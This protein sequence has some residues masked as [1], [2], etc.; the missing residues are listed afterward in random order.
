MS[1]FHRV[2][3]QYGGFENAI[4]IIGEPCLDAYCD[5]IYKK[6][7][8][9]FADNSY[10]KNVEWMIRIFHASKKMTLSALFFTQSEELNGKNFKNLTFYANYYSLF[11]AL[12]ANLILCPYLSLNKVHRISHSQIFA[13]IDNYFVRSKIYDKDVI[14]LLNDLRFTRELYSY[15][16]PLQGSCVN[17]KSGLSPDKL[18]SSLQSKIKLILQISNLLSYMCYFAWEKKIG[19]PIDQYDLHSEKVDELFFS[20]IEHHD[21]LG[22]HCEI[23]DEDYRTLGNML[24][25][26]QAPMPISWFI[27]QKVCEEL[28]CGWEQDEGYCIESVAQ[29]LSDT[30]D[31]I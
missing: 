9:E 25:K 11:H 8:K 24:N 13:D 19:I 10:M 23:D 12:S 14:T 27:T 31:A 7:C 22:F 4:E 3:K 30:I 2:I 1:L 5:K 20:F 18:T 6:F 28:E 16:L 21:H 26:W 15:H 29:F 17:E